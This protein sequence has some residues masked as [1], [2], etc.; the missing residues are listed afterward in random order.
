MEIL[1]KVIEIPVINFVVTHESEIYRYRGLT[2]V[3][4]HK[5]KKVYCH[6]APFQIIIHA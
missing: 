2:L 4:F 5:S 1:F 3:R 6:Y